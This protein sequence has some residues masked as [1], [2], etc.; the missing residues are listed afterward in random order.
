MVSSFSFFTVYARIRK[1]HRDGMSVRTV[2]HRGT[3]APTADTSRLSG[4]TADGYNTAAEL[5]VAP[6]RG[7]RTSGL[8]GFARV[9]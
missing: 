7:C 6:T 1:A 2:P 8:L 3:Q 4:A 9:T 5:V